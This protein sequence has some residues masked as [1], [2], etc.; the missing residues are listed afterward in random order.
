MIFSSLWNLFKEIANKKAIKVTFK[1]L[2]EFEDFEIE[3]EDIQ[4]MVN[5]LKEL[6]GKNTS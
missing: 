3:D 2:Q 4:K 1:I 5:P 6:V